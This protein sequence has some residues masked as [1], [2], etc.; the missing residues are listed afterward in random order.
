MKATL[1]MSFCVRHPWTPL[2]AQAGCMPERAV[3]QVVPGLAVRAQ[4]STLW[5]RIYNAT[6]WNLKNVKRV[7]IPIMFSL[8]LYCV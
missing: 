2:R 5:E 1:P 4:D 3:Q 7:R 8:L 6:D